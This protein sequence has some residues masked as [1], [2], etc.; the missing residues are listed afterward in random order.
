M[1]VI[2][3]RHGEP[4]VASSDDAPV[5]PELTARG[6]WQAERLG[7]WLACEQIDQVITSTMR[8]AQQTALPLQRHL[9]LRN[10]VV[11]DFDEID[12]QSRVYAPFHLLKDRFPD[13]WE[14]LQRQD[15][16]YLGW[17]HPERFAARVV[18]AWEDLVARRPGERVFIA[19]H[20][21]VIGSITSHLLGI[22]TR[23]AFAN[24][25]FA[26]YSRIHVDVDGRGQV[27]S[28][29]EVGHFDAS[30][31]RRIGP[32]GEGFGSAG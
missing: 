17:D 25:P 2:L 22:T 26:S 24:P 18:A 9:G 23:F 11:E 31:E 6:R 1:E 14:A 30:R 3:A 19:C 16:E 8:R 12:R 15:W 5:D 10:E 29:N 21:G 28:A 4:V 7:H 20:G 32:E 27:L 13:Q